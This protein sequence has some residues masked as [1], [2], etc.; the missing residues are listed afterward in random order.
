MPSR[1]VL[2]VGQCGA[3][4]SAIARLV[5]RVGADAEAVP[6]DSAEEALAELRGGGYALVL[7]NRVFDCGG[8]GL[9]LIA[10]IKADEAVR[11]V[12]VMLVSDYPSA[13]Q[14]AVELG[15][16]PGFGKSALG[17]PET[18]RRLTAALGGDG[19]ASGSEAG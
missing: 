12:P 16:L 10:R 8:S 5:R 19:G 9:D 6:A 14:Q 3:D 18:A 15:A 11:D 2:S 17:A 4:H 13:Q 1:R 7:V